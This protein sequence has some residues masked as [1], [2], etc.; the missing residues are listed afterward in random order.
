M[1]LINASVEN[2]ERHRDLETFIATN[3]DLQIV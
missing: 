3:I 1:K 2:Q